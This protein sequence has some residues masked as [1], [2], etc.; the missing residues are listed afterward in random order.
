MH[1]IFSIAAAA[2]LFVSATPVFAAAL[3]GPYV[4]GSLALSESFSADYTEDGGYKA[5]FTAS[6]TVSSADLL[7]GY[8]FVTSENIY[9]AFEAYYSLGGASETLINDPSVPVSGD[10]EKENAFGFKGK[11]GLAFNNSSAVYGI[12][13]YGRSE[14]E[15]TF[16]DNSGSTSDSDDFSG[17]VTGV[18]GAYAI[19]KSLVLT[20]EGT[21]TDYDKE[22]YEFSFDPAI[23]PNE[24]RVNIGLA[25]Q[26]DI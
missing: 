26:F 10:L 24:T 9:T 18:G 25:Y 17:Y 23:D 7:A 14:A 20:V 16:T 8:S 13:G 19:S 12:L 1:R 15:I 5:S 2:T 21:Y 22:S 6:E 4:G 3:T 11:L